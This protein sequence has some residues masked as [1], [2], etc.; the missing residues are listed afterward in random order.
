MNFTNQ[1]KALLNWNNTH[2]VYNSHFTKD[3]LRSFFAEKFTVIA[4]GK[5][6]EANYDNYFEFLNE[7]RN[8]IESISYDVY[9]YLDGANHTT[10]PLKAHIFRKNGEEENF[11]AILILKFDAA[12]KVILWHEV[13][14]T[15]SV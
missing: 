11:E 13:Y 2:L 4:N 10:I 9:E 3:D 14:L 6:F 15:L 12:G 5:H 1:A 8:S 7:F